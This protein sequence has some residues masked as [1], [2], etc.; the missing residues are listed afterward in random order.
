MPCLTRAAASRHPQRGMS[1]IEVLVSLVILSMGVLAVVALQL[2]SKRN[3]AD[4]GQRTVAAQLAY[5]IIE[6]M[7]ANSTTLALQNYLTGSTPLGNA[8][9]GGTTPPN[10]NCAAVACTE[11][12]MAQYDLWAWE[13][14]VDGAGEFVT[15]G[16]GTGGLIYPVGCIVGPTSG[17]GIYTIT[18]A[19]R[20][21]IRMTDINDDSDATNNVACGNDLTVGGVRVY[22]DSD[23]FRRTL[24]LQ[25]Y[26]TARRRT[27]A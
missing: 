15:A 1:L 7:R 20:G 26:I 4:A 19:W 14:A 11:V 25:V 22:G 12:Q 5:D 21:S 6:R 3:N 9:R 16:S 10:P 27:A 2:V 8:S 24:S 17:D 13:N 18:I 23:E